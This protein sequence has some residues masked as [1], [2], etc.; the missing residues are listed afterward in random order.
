MAQ[1]T[2]EQGE[3]RADQ[4]PVARLTTE[5]VSA[6]VAH[7]PVAASDLPRLIVVVGAE[8]QA[9]GRQGKPAPEKPQPAVPIRRSI[10]PDRLTCLVCGKRH[11]MLKR[12]LATEHGLTPG[13]YRDLFG[14][15]PDYP[16][17]APT[18]SQ[19]RA[20]LAQKIGLGRLGKKPAARRRR[21]AKSP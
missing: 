6:Y 19:Q 3:D 2:E 17:V 15:R 9:V 21:S 11:K 8:L 14:L 18:Y 7:N 20:E 16:M 4:T 1:P 12:H 13:E 10:H 5:I